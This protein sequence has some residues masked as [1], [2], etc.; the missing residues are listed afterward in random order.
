[1]WRTVKILAFKRTPTLFGFGRE[2]WDYILKDRK[3]GETFHHRYS[4]KMPWG[5]GQIVEVWF[6]N[7]QFQ[8]EFLK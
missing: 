6:V 2:D 4:S 8:Q 3:T 1:M 5:M 7:Q